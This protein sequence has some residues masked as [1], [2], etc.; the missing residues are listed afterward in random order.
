MPARPQQARSRETRRKLLSAAIESVSE[1]GYAGATMDQVVERA[2]VSRGAQMHHFPTKSLLMQAAFTE[3]LDAMIEDLAAQTE[4]IR[5]RQQKPSAVFRHL[6]KTYFSNRL[7][8]VTIELIVASRT[9]GELR[10]VL[11]PVT[12]RFHRQIDDCFG[13]IQSDDTASA[14]NVGIVVNLTMSLLRG[15]GVQTVLYDRPEAFRKQLSDWLSIVEQFLDQDT[16]MT[17]VEARSPGFGS[18]P[19]RPECSG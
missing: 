13:V 16:D 7:F 9:D 19:G 2:G 6:W 5:K 10:N 8:A 4:R 11:S 12:E 18:A 17:S 1:L 15:M 14:P 3:M